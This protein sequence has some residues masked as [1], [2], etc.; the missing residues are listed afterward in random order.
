M[1]PHPL[2]P[3]VLAPFHVLSHGH[4]GTAAPQ[5]RG[6]KTDI[7]LSSC[8]ETLYLH[9]QETD[10][11]LRDNLLAARHCPAL[12][13]IRLLPQVHFGS[14][15]G[16][17]LPPLFRKPHVQAACGARAGI[18]TSIRLYV[19]MFGALTLSALVPV[20]V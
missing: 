12:P 7:S 20:E 18:C 11:T 2:G 14:R 10:T 8:C 9:R 3:K 4:Q 19:C 5:I 15:I 1:I 6:S 16:R 13:W 17:L